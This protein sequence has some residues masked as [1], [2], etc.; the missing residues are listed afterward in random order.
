MLKIIRWSRKRNTQLG[1]TAKIS[2][3]QIIKKSIQSNNL[4]ESTK[5]Y[6]A[7]SLSKPQAVLGKLLAI[8]V[9]LSITLFL[10]VV[11]YTAIYGI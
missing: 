7:V 6:F 3:T 10:L 8:G 11:G 1:A 4:S 2:Q 5:D 9:I